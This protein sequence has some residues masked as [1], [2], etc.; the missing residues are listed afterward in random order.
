[1]LLLVDGEKRLE[2]I[3]DAKQER[4]SNMFHSIKPWKPGEST[5]Y[6]LVW[7]RC[8]ELSVQFWN[9][10]CFTKTLVNVRIFKDLDKE[11]SSFAKLDNIRILISTAWT[12]M[13][14]THKRIKINKQICYVLLLK[15][16]EAKE[17][18]D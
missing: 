16:A 6:R 10:E 14:N 8:F 9:T 12:G 17:E 7:V 2:D 13:T 11:T 5:R 1:M 3:I 15:K 4:W 18:K